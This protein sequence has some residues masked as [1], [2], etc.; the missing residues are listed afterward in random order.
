MIRFIE[1]IQRPVVFVAVF[2]LV[3]LVFAHKGFS[4]LMAY[5]GFNY[6]VGDS[7]TNSSAFS[8]GDSFGWGGRW[9]SSLLATNVAGSLHYADANGNALLTDGGKVIIGAI[10]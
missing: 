9:T 1:I 7:L 6:T 4:G 3:F 2:A 10:A 5:E 8:A